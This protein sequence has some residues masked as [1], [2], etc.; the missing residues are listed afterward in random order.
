MSSDIII[1]VLV[2]V[3]V[4]VSFILEKIPLALTAVIGIVVLI[5][6]GVL[7]PAQG[8]SGFVNGSVVLFFGMFIVGG[9]LAT[10]G[11]ASQIGRF[12]TKFAKTERQTIVLLMIAAGSVSTFVANT[13]VAAIFIP[14]V[15]AIAKESK[16][17]RSV[18]FMPM[19]FATSMAGG[20]TLVSTPPNLI[21]HSVLYEA[22]GSGF[23]FFD[24]A[25]VTI[26]RAI[27]GI[28]F[29]AFI[30]YK[31][32]PRITKYDDIDES[33]YQAVDYSH[34]PNWKRTAS[35][36]LLLATTAAIVLSEQIGVPVHVASSIGAV[37]AVL[38]RL[39]TEKEAYKAVDWPTI[40]LFAGTLALAAAVDTSG[41]GALFATQFISLLGADPRPIV[42]LIGLIV[43]TAILTQFMSNTATAAVL[44]PVVLAIALR[45]GI[46]PRSALMAIAIGS[47]LSYASPI[48]TPPNTMVYSIG[49]YK[50]TDYVKNGL[51]VIGI[52]FIISIVLL[53]IFFPF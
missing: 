5:V 34:I 37:L 12:V 22:T 27:L 36:V 53:P 46:D 8:F 14:I 16:I 43:L 25:V 31:R 1:T 21:V 41:A 20:M 15:F 3:F 9:A 40:F 42:L 32:L 4:V 38:L 23:N 13:A 26:P 18:L 29:F 10:T 39:M 19:A 7:T 2:L 17:P 49:G 30:G 6:T 52:V 45:M 35:V 47:T 28:L 48:A 51:P 11:A 24:F 33:K 50:F 44:S